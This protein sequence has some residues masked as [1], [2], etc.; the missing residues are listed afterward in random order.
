MHGI[1]CSLCSL[2][3]LSSCAGRA[4]VLAPAAALW[5][6]PSD[7]TGK[8]TD[9]EFITSPNDPLGLIVTGS[10]YL[11]VSQI[12]VIGLSTGTVLSKNALKCYPAF[13]TN[14]AVA[15]S[16]DG[17]RIFALGCNNMMGQMIMYQFE[18]GSVDGTPVWQTYLN[19]TMWCV[20]HRRASAWLGPLAQLYCLGHVLAAFGPLR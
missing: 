8:I 17:S 5:T 13:C 15:A 12:S 9:V 14:N 6:L 10:T 1:L 11:P 20:P 2:F 3:S 19:G 7:K 16:A 18:N 4:A